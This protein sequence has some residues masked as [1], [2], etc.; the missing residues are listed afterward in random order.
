MAFEVRA[1]A[2]VRSSRSELLDDHWDRET[3]TIELLDDVDSD[4]LLGLS[5]FSHVEVICMANRAS[6][7]PPGPWARHPRGNSQWPQVG[8]F[9]QRNK[10]RPNRLLVSVARIVSLHE[11]SL[12]VEGLDAVDGTPVVDIK[13][14]FAWG[15][16][17]GTLR[18]PKW[19]NEIGE[20]YFS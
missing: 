6:D 15:G 20:Q 19:A 16:P 18:V 14:V 10:D 9:A 11:R 1:V 5:D 13:P 17:R 12:M 2:V 7:V 8:V 4:A 3:T